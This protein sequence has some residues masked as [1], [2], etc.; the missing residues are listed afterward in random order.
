[1]AARIAALVLATSVS[2]A[3]C[4]F[5]M[6][7]KPDLENKKT[8]TVGNLSVEYA[9][10]WKTEL[11]TDQIEGVKF[12]SLTVESAGNAIALV[13]IF[14]PGIEMGPEEIFNTYVEGMVEASETEFGGVLD[15]SAHSEKEFSRAVLGSTWA[16]RTGTV[17]VKLLGEKVPNRIQTVQH[18]NDER[19]V[20][21]VVQAPVED[22]KTASPGFDAIYDG[23]KETEG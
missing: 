2:W 5:F 8:T 17:D 1:M 21:I 12:S 13:Q 4:G 18:T 6:E 16:G 23:L 19:T 10:N 3:G 15:L 9:G 11:E 7:P 20:I 14:E 22:W